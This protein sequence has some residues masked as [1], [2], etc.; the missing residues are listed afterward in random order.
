VA[1]TKALV[2]DIVR[3]T[4]LFT[5]KCCTFDRGHHEIGYIRKVFDLMVIIK[6]VQCILKSIPAKLGEKKTKCGI[7]Y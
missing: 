3:K 6:D 1:L 4:F 7:L 5:G 2:K